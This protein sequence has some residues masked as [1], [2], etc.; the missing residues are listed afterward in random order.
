VLDQDQVRGPERHRQARRAGE[1]SRLGYEARRD[2]DTV[3]LLQRPGAGRWDLFTC[4]LSLRDVEPAVN[5]VLSDYGL[6]EDPSAPAPRGE[7]EPA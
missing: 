3:G 6:D 1:G 4:L 2:R 7:G 5:L